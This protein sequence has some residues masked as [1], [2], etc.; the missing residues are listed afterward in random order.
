M[1]FLQPYLL[2]ISKQ[3]PDWDLEEIEELS[4]DYFLSLNEHRSEEK[5]FRAM[6]RWLD[7]E[8][9]T[10]CLEMYLRGKYDIEAVPKE[11]FGHTTVEDTKE[12]AI[13]IHHLYKK[14]GTTILFDDANAKIKCGDKV[15]LVGRNG[16]GKSTLLKMLIGK[17]PIDSGDIVIKK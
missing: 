10:D 15:A 5:K 2:E 13:T 14:L 17:E 12:D 3:Y 11:L 4:Q 1:H 7:Q 8:F 16:A 6:L 9:D